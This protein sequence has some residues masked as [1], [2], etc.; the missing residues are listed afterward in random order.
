MDTNVQ[1]IWKDIPNFPDHQASNL[2]RVKRVKAAR[3]SVIGHVISPSFDSKGYLMTRLKDASGVYRHAKM[4]RMVALA[5]IPNPDNCPQV[6][7]KNGVKDDNRLENLEWCDNGQNQKHAYKVLNRKKTYEGK[8]GKDHNRSIR[9]K[10]TN[11]KTGVV[12]YF[13]GYREVAEAKNIDP[14][15]VYRTLTGEY[16]QFKGYTIEKD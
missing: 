1:E 10:V 3:G 13:Y 4:H 11:I 8:F 12:E 14:S 5:F 2:G 6:N 9:F 15:N 7:H 16:K